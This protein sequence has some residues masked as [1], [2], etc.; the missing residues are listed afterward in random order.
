MNGE[1][2]YNLDVPFSTDPLRLQVDFSHVRH[3]RK[4]H[5]SPEVESSIEVR[6]QAR[7]SSNPSLFNASKFR[8]AGASVDR[9]G[10]M[11]TVHLGLTDYKTFQGTH[12]TPDALL[13]FGREGLALPMG[14]AIAVETAD[15]LVP[16]LVRCGAVGEGAGLAVMPGGHAEPAEIGIH[17]D[18]TSKGSAVSNETVAGELWHAARREVFEEL[19][20]P[21]EALQELHFLGIVSRQA[22]AKALIA[23]TAK[24]SMSSEEVRA[25]YQ[26]EN[27]D[28]EE[29]TRIIFVPLSELDDLLKHR[30]L[31]G[32]EIM[33]DHL[34][35][36]ALAVQFFAWRDGRC[37]P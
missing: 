6:W 13:T 29:S 26:A 12:G 36:L 14:N 25:A 18:G 20:V 24:L 33:P 28:Q 27:K 30:S 4:P 31:E 32:C 1:G 15:A 7:L 5:P 9:V 17:S 2:G 21:E 3:G 10:R 11:V 35:S 34:G 37:A 16:F 8:Y 22:D 19:F 23:F